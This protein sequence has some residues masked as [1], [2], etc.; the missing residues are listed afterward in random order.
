MMRVKALVLSW[1]VCL[2]LAGAAW[3]GAV[4]PTPLVSLDA[5]NLPLG[6]L[7]AWN[8]Q[9]SLL[10][11][12]G[13]SPGQFSSIGAPPQVG[14]VAGRKAVTF[15]GVNGFLSTFPLP[16]SL[17]GNGA[18]SVSLWALSA[19]IGQADEQWI[20]TWTRSTGV[21]QVAAVGLGRSLTSG[22]AGHGGGNGDMGW[23]RG[24][25]SEGEWHNIT[26]TFSG[27]TNWERVYLDGVLVGVEQKA[28][29]LNVPDIGFPF[30]IG[31]VDDPN[32]FGKNFIGS[33][34]SIQ[35]WEAELTAD[36]VIAAAG[37]A[38][39][40]PCPAV[41]NPSFELPRVWS[42]NG[43]AADNRSIPG[44]CLSATYDLACTKRAGIGVCGPN[45]NDY[46]GG[47]PWDNGVNPD[48]NRV[49]AL[50]ATT[51]SSQGVSQYCYFYAGKT[52]HL[53]FAY[54]ATAGA[55]PVMTVL[56][57]GVPIGNK[58]ITVSAV[59]PA[60]VF[61]SPF[62]TFDADFTVPA[63][64]FCPI[65]IELSC[66]G[67]GNVLLI[68]DVR[69]MAADDPNPARCDQAGGLDFGL[70]ARNG[71]VDT[72]LTLRNVAGAMLNFGGNYG[73]A[74]GN[75]GWTISGLD[76][77]SFDF[78]YIDS[79]K[80]FVRYAN[81]SD[82]FQLAG[83]GVGVLPI[84]R[85]VPGPAVKTH[86]ATLNLTWSNDKDAGVM[87]IPL[88][89]RVAPIPEVLNGSF[90]QP[91]NADRGG[92]PNAASLCPYAYYDYLGDNGA[93][94]NWLVQGSDGGWRNGGAS[95]IGVEDR[96]NGGRFFN[97]GIMP[98]GR[99]GL[100]IQTIA[101][102]PATNPDGSASDSA[103][104][105]AFTPRL[106][107]VR[108]Y[109]G[110]FVA[111]HSYKISLWAGARNVGTGRA[112]LT[113][114]MDG[115]QL[116]AANPNGAGGVT[117]NSGP[118]DALRPGLTHTSVTLMAAANLAKL[119]FDWVATTEGPAALDLSA[120]TR[121]DNIGKRWQVESALLV[122]KVQIFDMAVPHAAA[123]P[124]VLTYITDPVTNTYMSPRKTFRSAQLNPLLYYASKGQLTG[125]L[126]LTLY[127]EGGGPLDVTDIS[128]E[129]EN[130][131][132]F[133]CPVTNLTGIKP[134]GNSATIDVYFYPKAVGYVTE[135]LVLTTNDSTG[136]YKIALQGYAF[137]G[138]M[139]QNNSFETPPV[140]WGA[141]AVGTSW[142]PGPY[143]WVWRSTGANIVPSYWTVQGAAGYTGVST[144]VNSEVI[145]NGATFR[146]NNGTIQYGTQA[147]WMMPSAPGGANGDCLARQTVVGFHG[148]MSYYFE[149]WVN[150]RAIG[151]NKANFILRITDPLQGN[152]WVADVI[153]ASATVAG[154]EPVAA[155]DNINEFTHP[156][157]VLEG[158]FYAPKSQPY[159]VELYSPYSPGN[160][161]LLI[162][163]ILVSPEWG[164]GVKEWNR[165]E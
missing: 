19:N 93:I 148:M 149:V 12:D 164:C 69:V 5:A 27:P 114:A 133:Y 140:Y 135:K 123:N 80:N 73:T 159:N 157:T 56:V 25:P 132:H 108:Q 64:G 42:Q 66:I 142:N 16:T 101:D 150:A 91:R 134:Y 15:N 111:G 160:G 143:A 120:I 124:Q 131:R 71:A 35:V 103:P 8:S 158:D 87:A 11:P 85:F 33:L 152:A 137:G 4:V 86:R 10:A 13:K 156:Y 83:Y 153:T 155:V 141:D 102:N 90:E 81:N 28:A 89:G 116:P 98:D 37:L 50:A 51:T 84:V 1:A 165:Y 9:G 70:A 30:L 113:V 21:G 162:D 46:A 57:D 139:V 41:V 45:L 94:P 40:P 161:A 92:Y 2:M 65:A 88:T 29:Q 6:D 151:D 125:P 147:L 129:G 58:P 60:G 106:R 24:V 36:Q 82:I 121:R 53:H 55:S 118:Y 100:Y 146:V 109:L 79:G 39:P 72:S 23:D 59:D 52:Y 144:A 62:H 48:G 26:V 138:P 117:I 115:V 126:T 97:Q 76:A 77:A 67:A 105:G 99:Q 34:S 54:N 130:A 22:V 49:L 110:G 44:W 31:V 63:T 112:S 107:T 17:T 119:E 68:D 163:Q 18:F 96:E 145:N 38:A 136:T 3:G 7:F 104:F 127:N 78:G 122:D 95:G 75:S 14:L 47:S 74:T 154:S 128:M 61:Q 20:L 32:S 43:A